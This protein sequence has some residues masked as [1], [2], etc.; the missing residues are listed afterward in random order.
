MA[1]ESDEESEREEKITGKVQELKE[2]APGK[3]AHKIKALTHKASKTGASIVL[4]KKA[5]PLY[6]TLAALYISS[7][8]AANFLFKSGKL[9]EQLL[10]GKLQFLFSLLNESLM[11]G[12]HIKLVTTALFLATLWTTYFYWLKD[13]KHIKR[14]YKLLRKIFL[15]GTAAVILQRHVAPE[16]P[17]ITVSRWAVFILTIYIEVAGTWFAAKIIDGID[18]SSDLKNW[19]LKLASLP[20]I[21]SGA[22]VSI[23]ARPV[24]TLSYTT[25]VYSN[26]V[27]L[28]GLL[29]MALGTFMIYRSTR[30]EPALKVW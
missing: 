1:E 14:S 11:M 19:T 4:S 12:S 28:G 15:V 30:R 8:R 3:A 29:I 6:L 16:S 2:S 5:L 25:A 27:F 24:I 20:T 9:N 21:I 17:L 7:F 22:A 26:A 23:T 10:Q 13:S 18:L